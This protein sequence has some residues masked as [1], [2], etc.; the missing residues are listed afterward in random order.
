VGEVRC[1]LAWCKSLAPVWVLC[2]FMKE[3]E[4]MI[5]DLNSYMQKGNMNA[6]TK[7]MLFA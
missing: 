1:A 4:E 2:P 6:N 7:K 3:E 5:L